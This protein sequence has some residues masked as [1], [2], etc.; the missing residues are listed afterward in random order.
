[1]GIPISSFIMTGPARSAGIAP[2]K[3]VPA[4]C[5]IRSIGGSH[6]FKASGTHRNRSRTVLKLLL[7]LKLRLH[8]LHSLSPA[9]TAD[10]LHKEIMDMDSLN[11]LKSWLHDYLESTMQAMDR[12]FG[13]D[14]KWRRPANTCPFGDQRITLDEVAGCLHLNPSYFSRMF[15][16]E[17]GS[18]SSN[19]SPG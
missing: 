17:T 11:E 3:R 6:G 7:D 5:A 15:K 4:R 10:A 19:T 9:Y 2:A 13:E 8:L 18:P 12:G 1:M 14:R 16:K